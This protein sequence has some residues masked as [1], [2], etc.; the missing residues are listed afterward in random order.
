VAISA[1][2]RTWFLV[3]ASPDL[4]AQI[5]AF[6]ALQPSSDSLRNSPIAG[7][8]LTNAD[9]DHVLGLYLL[10]ERNNLKV[11]APNAV[12]AAVAGDL[13]LAEILKPFCRIHWQET[14]SSSQPLVGEDGKPT[15]LR[16]SAIPLMAKAPPFAVGAATLQGPHS[17]AYQ[18]FDE[19]THR[20]LLV[21]PDVAVITSELR[22][23]LNAADGVLFDGTFWSDD[24][25]SKL[26]GK[27]RTSKDMGHL[28]VLNGSLDA[29]GECQARHKIYL[30]IN[31][32]N[33]IL[34]PESP[35]HAAV[36]RAGITVGE[37]GQEFV[38]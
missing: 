28:P 36:A 31:N 7:V 18:F 19:R 29:L 9:L 20:R 10:R 33:P 4:R 1:D 14:A 23:A 12:W 17:V 22:V 13:H 6:P 8:L 11:I 37:D 21:A 30:H 5:E 2:G 16:F 3:N 24:E 15:G 35:A 25:F 34:D 38:L 27:P 26:T 32:T